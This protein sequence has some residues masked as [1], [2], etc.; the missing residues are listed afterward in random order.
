MAILEDQN[1]GFLDFAVF[2]VVIKVAL[3]LVH[4]SLLNPK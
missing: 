1:N 2:D 4:L 3:T